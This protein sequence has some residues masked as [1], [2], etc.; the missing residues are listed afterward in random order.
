MAN[1]DPERLKVLLAGIAQKVLLAQTQ[2]VNEGM[3]ELRAEFIDRIFQD[4]RDS[5]NGKIGSYST[6]PI[7]VSPDSLTSQVGKSGLKPKGKNPN[8]KAKFKNGKARKSQYFPDGYKGFRA[9]VGRQNEAVDLFLTGS[10]RGDIRLGS[11][12]GRVELAFTT[13]KQVQIAAGN[14]SRFNK[15]IFAPTESELDIVVERWRDEVSNA[16]LNSFE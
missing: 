13:D 2:S 12:D 3:I 14:E 16:F 9:A 8:S 4:G 7:Y 5:D 10:L 6:K 15:T 11:L 1:F